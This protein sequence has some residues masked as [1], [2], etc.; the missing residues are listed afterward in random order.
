MQNIHIP[1]SVQTI[2]S[3]AFW[4]CAGLT[5]ITFGAGSQLTSIYNNAFYGCAALTDVMLPGDVD[6]IAPY[7]FDGCGSLTYINI[8]GGVSHIGAG[9]FQN[10]AG[11][12]TLDIERESPLSAVT[13]GLNAFLNCP[14]AAILVPDSASFAAYTQAAGWSRRDGY[15]F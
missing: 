6:Y 2:E 4:E 13:I 14:L 3:F 12:T 9:A 8:P 7:A 11:L 5:D 10:C 1:G 15:V